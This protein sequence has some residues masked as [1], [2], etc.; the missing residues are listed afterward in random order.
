MAA[1]LPVIAT[2]AGSILEVVENGRDG[3]LVPQRDPLA[4]ADAIEALVREPHRRRQISNEAIDTVRGRF[5]VRACEGIFHE[6]VR[7]VIGTNHDLRRE[8]PSVV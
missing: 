4:L 6:R 2:D 1:G 7:T 8:G 3:I 5:D